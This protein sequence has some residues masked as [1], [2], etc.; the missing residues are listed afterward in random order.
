MRMAGIDTFHLFVCDCGSRTCSPSPWPTGM[1]D[2]SDSRRSISRIVASWVGAGQVRTHVVGLPG[3]SRAQQLKCRGQSI[4]ILSKVPKDRAH[5]MASCVTHS[6][7]CRIGCMSSQAAAPRPTAQHVQLTSP[8]SKNMPEL[9]RISEKDSDPPFSVSTTP[10]R[11]RRGPA[12]A[13]RWSH[14]SVVGARVGKGTGGWALL[15][16]VVAAWRRVPLPV[17]AAVQQ[18]GCAAAQQ[19]QPE[20]QG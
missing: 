17:S 8:R 15:S 20:L 19:Q 13:T 5:A 1:R 7:A 9:V 4:A 10:L 3:K 11:V 14:S 18:P 16:Q 2:H 12:L 6:Q